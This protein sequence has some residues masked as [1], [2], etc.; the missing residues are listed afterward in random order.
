MDLSLSSKGTSKETGT[1]L[2]LIICKEFVEK[3]NG[4]IM[5]ESKKNIGTTFTISLPLE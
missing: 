4:T 2:G 3:H 5:V 1:G